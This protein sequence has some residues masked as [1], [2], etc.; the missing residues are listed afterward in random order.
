M[1]LVEAN[2]LST[3]QAAGDILGRVHLEYIELGLKQEE[4][5]ILEVLPPASQ[6]L[7]N[8]LLGT[9]R[10]IAD[11]TSAQVPAFGCSTALSRWSFC[12]PTSC[13]EMHGA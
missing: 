11:V 2:C 8:V 4:L 5:V 7:P 9:T 10:A 1:V 13:S 6:N 12:C 3:G